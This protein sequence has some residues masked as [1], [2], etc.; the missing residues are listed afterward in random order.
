ML[1]GTSTSVPQRADGLVEMIRQIKVA[2]DN[3]QRTRTRSIMML[4][5]VVVNAP[6]EIREQLDHRGNKAFQ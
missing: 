2:R 6:S 1:A 5:I 3:A 4:K